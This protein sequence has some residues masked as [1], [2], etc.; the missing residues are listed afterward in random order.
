MGDINFTIAKDVDLN[1]VVN[2]D[3][4]KNV[5]VEVNNGTLWVYLDGEDQHWFYQ[6]SL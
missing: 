1:K 5:N 2:L 4:D 6:F 3:I